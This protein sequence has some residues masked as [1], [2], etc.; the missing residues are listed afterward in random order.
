MSGWRRHVVPAVA[1]GVF[2]AA[3]AYLIATFEWRAALRIL[4]QA[5]LVTFFVGASIALLAYWAARAA[6]WRLLMEA[7]G[8]RC[9]FLPVYL[10]STVALSLSVLTPL[11]SGEALKVELLRKCADVQRL[12]GYGAFILERAAD[13]YAIVALGLVAATMSRSSAG[14][15]ALTAVLLALPFAGYPLARAAPARGR[16]GGILNRL[17]SGIR[18]PGMLAIFMGWTLLAWCLVAAA[19]EACLR[20]LSIALGASEIFGLIAVVTLAT[21]ASFVPAGL[22]IAEASVSGMLIRYGIDAPHAQAG[23][24]A[25]RAF[26]LLVVALG[27]LH[28][29]WLRRHWR[30][31]DAVHGGGNAP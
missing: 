4:A 17:L 25:L 22:G 15:I 11:Q 24:L 12:P 5:D 10:C 31:A 19:W 13:F 1:A 28:L 2:I 26:T 6:R 7:M 30:I 20:S 8:S 18:S 9:P 27:A 16:V 29:P 23:A 21:L 3:L 14:A